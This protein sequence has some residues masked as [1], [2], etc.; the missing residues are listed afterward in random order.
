MVFSEATQFHQN[1]G[2]SAGNLK[3]KQKTIMAVIPRAVVTLGRK[4]FARR[5]DSALDGASLAQYP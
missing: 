4:T 1:H 2:L 5:F 3:H